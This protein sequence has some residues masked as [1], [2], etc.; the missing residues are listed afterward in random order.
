MKDEKEE[1][2][3]EFDPIS[4]DKSK[5]VLEHRDEKYKLD[6]DVNMKPEDL[7]MNN[8]EENEKILK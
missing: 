8:R 1:E 5:T 3:F 6:M 7:L 2:P 4:K